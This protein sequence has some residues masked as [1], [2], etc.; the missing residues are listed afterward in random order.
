MK[1][2]KPFHEI[3]GIGS[4]VRLVCARCTNARLPS[5][6]LRRRW[7]W[8][9]EPRERLPDCAGAV[10]LMTASTTRRH[11]W[12]WQV[13]E[14]DLF[15]PETEMLPGALIGAISPPPSRS[16]LLSTSTLV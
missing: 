2:S 15:R 5:N 1:L 13:I 10:I 16:I 9:R 11:R 7:H 6:P 8:L 3:F 14:V 4:A 12:R